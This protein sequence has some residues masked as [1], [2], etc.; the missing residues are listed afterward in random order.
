MMKVMRLKNCPEFIAGDNSRLKEILNPRK[1][2]LKLTYSLAYAMVGPGKKTLR[3]RLE[4]TE[5]YFI[6]KGRGIMHINK[7][8]EDV[9]AGDT[10]YIPPGSI[11]YI[12][13]SGRKLLEFICIVEPAW[14]PE[15]EKVLEDNG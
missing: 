13:N 2:K 8:K 1:E 10:I 12:E 7:R 5:V 11:Q 4:Y 3:H 14:Q 6:T 9:S 15:C